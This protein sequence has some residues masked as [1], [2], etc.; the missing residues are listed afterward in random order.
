MKSASIK[1]ILVTGRR[2]FDRANGNTYCASKVY[3]D[4]KHVATTDWQYG[5][6]DFFIQAAAEEMKRLGLI[7]TNRG[8]PWYCVENDIELNYEVAD[9]LK[10]DLVAFSKDKPKEVTND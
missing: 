2:W 9:G 4:G 6:D 5:Y 8:L 3:I 7:D 10:R 1:T